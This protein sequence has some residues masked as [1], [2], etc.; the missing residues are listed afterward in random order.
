MLTPRERCLR[1]VRHEEVDRVPLALRIR[2]EPYEKLVETLGVRRGEGEYLRV[3]KALGIDELG[4]PGI[5][6]RSP[7]EPDR[8]VPRDE[9]GGWPIGRE[10]R[11][12]IH[13]NIW[14]VETIWAPDRT[15]TYTYRKHPFSKVEDLDGFPWPSVVEQDQKKIVDFRRRHENYYVGS[16]SIQ[17]F[18]TAWKMTGMPRFLVGM[19]RDDPLITRI[20]D[21]LFKISTRQAV[22]AAEAGVDFIYN[23]DDV[24]SENNM[25]VSPEL[26]RRHLKPRYAAM[27]GE[28]KRRGA[29]VMFH[30]DGWIEPIIP[31]LIEVGVDVLNPVQPEC[32]DPA[33]LKE[34]YGDELCFDGTIG[35]QSTL[36]HGT[37]EQVAREVRH[38]IKTCGPTGLILGPTHS[39]QPDVPV[40][41]IIAMYEA[42]RKEPL[43]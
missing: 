21:E 29:F 2:P 32:M 10:G 42:A 13:T 34:A 9:E 14:R 38:R 27:F 41:N 20:L 28:V 17:V 26:W 12:E 19:L 6:L 35:V 40:P 16:G 4:A 30:S 36:P 7:L 15:Y 39:M 1:A 3:C 24:G 43:A 23:G 8:S 37:P 33:K 31:D 22:L 25:I 5:G 18:E 11:F